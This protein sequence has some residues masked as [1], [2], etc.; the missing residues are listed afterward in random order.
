LVQKI[1]S[2]RLPAG[3]GGKNQKKS[4]G[5]V[6]SG[7]LNTLTDLLT[8]RVSFALPLIGRRPA[9]LGPTS[10]STSGIE[11]PSTKNSLRAAGLDQCGYPPSAYFDVRDALGLE[12]V[13]FWTPPEGSALSTNGPFHLLAASNCRANNSLFL[14]CRASATEPKSRTTAI[15]EESAVEKSVFLVFMIFQVLSGDGRVEVETRH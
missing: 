14:N 6:K 1:K 7:F 13:I 12:N 2:S 8:F 4:Y 9:Q 11:A 5:D 15:S 3:P 10:K